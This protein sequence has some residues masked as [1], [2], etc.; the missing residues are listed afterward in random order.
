MEKNAESKKVEKMA[1]TAIS[2]KLRDLIREKGGIRKLADK[3]AAKER[4]AL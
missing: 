2:S 4:K 3:L 1:L